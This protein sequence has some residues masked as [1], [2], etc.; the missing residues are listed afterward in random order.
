MPSYRRINKLFLLSVFVIAVTTA[1]AV[2]PNRGRIGSAFTAQEKTSKGENEEKEKR[3]V[4]IYS[5]PLPSDPVERALRR[6]R[7]SR[8]DNRGIRMDELPPDTTG[9]GV[10]SHWW[11]YMPSLPS[12]ESDAVVLGEAVGANAFL[13]NDKTGAYSEFTIRIEEVLKDSRRILTP[14]TSLVAE[15]DGANVQLPS[16]RTILYSIAGQGTPRIGRRYLFFLKYNDQGEDYSILTGYELREG[17]VFPLD[18]IGHF[19]N[20]KGADENTFSNAVREAVAR[21]R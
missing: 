5:A 21:P 20:Y 16:G 2:L 14:N 18:E 4:A 3:P 9:R 17:R 1:L 7:N 15:R 19:I 8:Y 13:S 10:L 12:A 11:E 6:A